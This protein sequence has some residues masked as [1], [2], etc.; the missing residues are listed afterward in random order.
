MARLRDTCDPELLAL[1]DATEEAAIAGRP[2]S[3]GR[4]AISSIMLHAATCRPIGVAIW[5]K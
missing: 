5:R 4:I 2:S 1:A 3:I